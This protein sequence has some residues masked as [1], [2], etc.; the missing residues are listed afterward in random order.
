MKIKCLV[1]PQITDELPLKSFDKYLL[2]I[3]STIN[4]ADSEFNNIGEIDILL[5]S[6][7]FWSILSIGQERLGQNMPLLQNTQ[8]GWVVAGNICLNSRCNESIS[9]LNVNM[10]N[11]IDDKIIK[12]WNIEEINNARPLLSQEEKYCEAHFE[13]TTRRDST[14]RFIVNVP[15]KNS[16][17][18]LGCPHLKVPNF[19]T[20]IFKRI[21]DIPLLEFLFYPA[22]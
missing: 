3:P 12:F 8:F 1:I 6:N 5:G 9:C 13:K 21:H 22:S 20:R 4:L 11:S 10:E 7:V 18:Y 15:F 14:G 16:L 19:I 2:N 17:S